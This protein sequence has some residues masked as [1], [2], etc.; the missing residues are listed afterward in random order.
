[1]S[2][3]PPIISTY[4][5]IQLPD[6]DVIGYPSL[7][8]DPVYEDTIY[9]S[10]S[11][12]VYAL[13]LEPWLDEVSHSDSIT[14]DSKVVQ[15]IK[16][17]STSNTQANP[18]VALDVIND[19]YLGYVLFALTSNM[20][21]LPLDLS[22]RVQEEPVSSR[23]NTLASNKQTNGAPSKE[24]DQTDEQNKLYSSL[25]DNPFKESSE[26]S[27]IN[28][29]IKLEPANTKGELEITPKT[30]RYMGGVVENVRKY[31]QTFIETGN[32]IQNRLNL[33]IKETERQIDKL[34]HVAR[35][36]TNPS[37]EAGVGTGKGARVESVSNEQNELLK[38]MDRL[39]Q[40]LMDKHQP[41]LSTHEKKW[42]AELG[43]IR[44][45][46][47]GSDGK[48]RALQAR[49][50]RVRSSLCAYSIADRITAL[51]STRDAQTAGRG[52]PG[53]SSCE[54]QP[55]CCYWSFPDS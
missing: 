5:S 34:A 28:L 15:V 16:T 42:F 43:R 49:M 51:T 12:G 52:L 29:T 25:L 27:Q 35:I 24:A 45:E 41:T 18:I 44:D 40:R 30:L 48:G 50:S 1:M 55:I 7:S 13:V 19:A 3:P 37:N 21:L 20:Q 33:Q 11:M 47:S 39:L 10:H 46:V 4:E 17:G 53:Q 31:N 8:R 14:K 26:N 2:A 9:I 23:E 22:L 32:S 54:K 36:A 38:R 6:V